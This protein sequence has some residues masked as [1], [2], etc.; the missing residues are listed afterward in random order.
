MREKHS[1]VKIV[2]FNLQALNI[3]KSHPFGSIIGIGC[4][5]LFVIVERPSFFIYFVADFVITQKSTLNSVLLTKISIL[6][7]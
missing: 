4:L 1:L 6:I 2:Y 5:L 7:E 3:V